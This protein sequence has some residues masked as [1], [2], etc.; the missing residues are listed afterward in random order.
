MAILLVELM[1]VEVTSGGHEVL[2]V[3]HLNEDGTRMPGLINVDHLLWTENV[4][5]RGRIV[6]ARPGVPITEPPT[7]KG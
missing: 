1:G 6:T 4:E 2:L 3:T 5:D 7:A